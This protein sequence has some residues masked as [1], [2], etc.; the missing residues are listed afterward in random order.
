MEIWGASSFQT[1]AQDDPLTHRLTSV[2]QAST[3][4]RCKANLGRLK[5]DLGS[6]MKTKLTVDMGSSILYQKT[7][8]AE[9]YL[10]SFS[11]GWC[12]PDFMKFSDDDSRTPW[13]HISHYIFQLGKA[14]CNNAFHVRLFSLSLSFFLVFFIGINWNVSFMITSLIGTMSQNC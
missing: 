5:E 13:D 12:A 14:S 11:A 6:M 8:L 3:S 9:F 2:A 1:M 4:G 7:Y 10:V